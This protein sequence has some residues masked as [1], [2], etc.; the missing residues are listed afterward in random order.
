MLLPPGDEAFLN[1]KGVPFEVSQEG[2]T[3]C[4]LLPGWSL[5]AGY[6]ESSS[7]LLLR[8]SAG[9]PDVPPDMWW[10]SPDLI[11]TDGQTI[12]ATDLHEEHLGRTWQR[13]SRHFNGGQWLP[14]HDTLE[15]FLALVSTDVRIH[16][17]G[18]A[19]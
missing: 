13:W 12:P 5:P 11:R 8:L 6:T 2:V 19:V 17:A 9:Y 18:V 10:F 1:D 16:A 4:V 15:S 14:G 3:T 7:D